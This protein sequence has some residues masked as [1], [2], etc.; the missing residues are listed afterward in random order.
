MA[1][2]SIS[3]FLL[4]PILVLFSLYFVKQVGIGWDTPIGY[5][6]PA[7]I[8]LILAQAIFTTSSGGFMISRMNYLLEIAPEE[9]RPSY[10]AFMNV[11]L[12]PTAFFPILGGLIVENF[13]F[14]ASFCMSFLLGLFSLYYAYKLGEPRQKNLAES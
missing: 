13:S 3:M 5:V 2:T 10:I 14:Q 6:T 9:Y 8:C 1:I 4:S 12:A 7:L 11:M